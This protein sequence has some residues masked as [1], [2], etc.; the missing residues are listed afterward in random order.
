MTCCPH[1]TLTMISPSAS[2]RSETVYDTHE[3][4]GH[5]AALLSEVQAVATAL[6][7]RRVA[8]IRRRSYSRPSLR[9]PSIAMQRKNTPSTLPANMP[10]VV[11]CHVLER[12]HASIVYPFHSIETVKSAP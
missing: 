10:V 12:K 5:E 6:A 3:L 1:E 2:K 4:P 8:R 9:A 11:M 7:V